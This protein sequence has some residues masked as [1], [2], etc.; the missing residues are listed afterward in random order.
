[1]LRINSNAPPALS[2]VKPVQIISHAKLALKTIFYTNIQNTNAYGAK[3]VQMQHNVTQM[4]HAQITRKFPLDK[5]QL[6]LYYQSTLW[7]QPPY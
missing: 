2:F 5:H 7:P 3:P 6:E 1:M 4:E